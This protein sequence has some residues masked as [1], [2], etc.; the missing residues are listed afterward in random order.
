M[1]TAM[2]FLDADNLTVAS[3][4]DSRWSW[5]IRLLASKARPARVVFSNGEHV[6]GGASGLQKV[7]QGLS[8]RMSKIPVELLRDSKC[9]LL[10]FSMKIDDLAQV[11]RWFNMVHEHEHRCLPIVEVS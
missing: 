9:V 2:F 3:L 8:R 1:R 6:L 4:L 10:S 7:D 11:F 5:L